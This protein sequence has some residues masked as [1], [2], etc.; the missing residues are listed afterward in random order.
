MAGCPR[1]S[2]APAIVKTPD[3]GVDMGL[4]LSDDVR[5]AM[6]VAAKRQGRTLDEI[7]EITWVLAKPLS[8]EAGAG[9]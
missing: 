7:V 2:L 9:P 6:D 3:G 4:L 5:G 8:K 1:R